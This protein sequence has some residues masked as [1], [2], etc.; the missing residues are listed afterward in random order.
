MRRITTRIIWVTLSYTPS[1]EAEKAIKYVKIVTDGN[2]FGETYTYSATAKAGCFTLDADKKTITLPEDA[3]GKVFVN[4]EKTGVA[5]AKVAKS[6]DKTPAVKSL[7]IHAIFHDPCD[8]NRVYAGVIYVPR[9]QIDPSSVELSLTMDG[10]HAATY[11][12]QKPY[13]ESDSNLFEIM[14]SEN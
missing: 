13:C 6:T 14:V 7:L 8:A 10:K 9:A 3:T 12:L 11:T 4:Y 1:G 5:V 2:V